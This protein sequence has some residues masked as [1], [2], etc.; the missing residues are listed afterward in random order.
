[1][2]K[3]CVALPDEGFVAPVVPS[4]MSIITHR[5]KRVFVILMA[6]PLQQLHQHRGLLCP[7]PWLHLAGPVAQPQAHGI[8]NAHSMEG[9]AA[10]L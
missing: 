6:A 5:K 8:I 4:I 9:K 3:Q 1:M 2:T 7:G 10:A